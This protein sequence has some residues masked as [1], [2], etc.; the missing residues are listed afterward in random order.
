MVERLED[1]DRLDQRAGGARTRLRRPGVV[2]SCSRARPFRSASRASFLPAA[3][4]L[5]ALLPRLLLVHRGALHRPLLYLSHYLKQNRAEYYDRL[6]AVRRRGDWEGWLVFFL[7]GVA[8]TATEATE[9]ARA[10]LG[11]RE[12]HRE[13]VGERTGL[14]GMRLLDL[15]YDR[16]LVNV[17]LVKD[18]LE[19]SFATANNLVGQ[20]E[21]ARVLREITG[22]RRRR[23]FSY[24]AYLALLRDDAPAGRYHGQ[25][26]RTASTRGT[27]E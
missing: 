9:T 27:A 23:V 7:D 25:V 12:R 8:A 26:Q 13:L 11:L 4:L 16:P 6:M 1:G 5:V 15:L 17:N 2:A 19:V 24:D 22:G 20:F 18:A 21:E 14:N 3:E 10:I